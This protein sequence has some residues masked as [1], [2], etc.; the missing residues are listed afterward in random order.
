MRRDAERYR[1]LCAVRVNGSE[2]R[3]SG[4]CLDT[5]VGTGLA[6]LHEPL[7]A[8]PMEPKRSRLSKSTPKLK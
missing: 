1:W 7:S 8:E 4:E 2:I 6:H 5:R 3:W